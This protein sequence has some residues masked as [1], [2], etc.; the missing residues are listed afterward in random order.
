MDFHMLAAL[1]MEY[2]STYTSHPL[3]LLF[4]IEEAGGGSR[5]FLP[6]LPSA[7]A[8]FSCASFQ[9]LGT[10]GGFQAHS[11]TKLIASL[12]GHLHLTLGWIWY[13]VFPRASTLS[14]LGHGG[15]I[16]YR[17]TTT[18]PHNQGGGDATPA[19]CPP[20]LLGSHTEHSSVSR[21]LASSGAAPRHVW[22]PVAIPVVT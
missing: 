18:D 1:A 11:P 7:V 17:T 15:S 9:R 2:Y 16:I 19:D 14:F 20:P 21:I 5:L 6:S 8:A 22:D 12:P 10:P 3:G 4:R 13:R